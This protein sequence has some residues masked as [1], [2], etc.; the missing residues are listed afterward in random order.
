MGMSGNTVVFVDLHVYYESMPY[1]SVVIKVGTNVLTKENGMLNTAAMNSLTAQLAALQKEGVKVVLISSGAMAAGRGVLKPKRPYKGVAGRQILSA[2]GQVELIH[3]YAKH[4]QE[5]GL[6]CAQVLAT[7]DDFRSR[8]HYLNMRGC[9]EALTAEGIIPIVNENDVVSVEELMFTDND[10]LA[11]LI[12]T[13]INADILVVLSSVEGIQTSDGNILAEVA[14]DDRAWKKHVH[15]ERSQFGR[16]GMHTKCETAL[17]LAR[18]GIETVIAAGA[19]KNVILDVLAG[20]SVGTRFLAKQGVSSTK[21]WV[22]TNEKS[23]SGSVYLNAR[24]CDILSD[25]TDAKSLLPVGITKVEG[26]FKKG[27]VIRICDSKGKDIAL[28][29]V[30]YDAQQAKENMGKKGKRPLVRYEYLYIF[31]E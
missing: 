7:K 11:G 30:S 19:R 12:A 6:H 1:S 8:R 23:A 20:M 18:V 13:M 22:G 3:T 25:D 2:V 5:H 26:E 24:A 9:M 10:E 15:E 4:L 16:G 28:G 27:D 21:R 17:K 14:S 31:H 29:M